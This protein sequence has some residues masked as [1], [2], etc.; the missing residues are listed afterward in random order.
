MNG[1]AGGENPIVLQRPALQGMRRFSHRAMNT[2]F[3][4][5]TIHGDAEYAAQASEEAFREIDRLELELSRFI[6]NSDVSR[7]NALKTGQSIR[8]GL[9]TFACLQ[10]SL[11]MHTL[12]GGAFD[13]AAGA[14]RAERRKRRPSTTE[15]HELR[16]QAGRCP[17]G[18][19]FELNE[20]DTTITALAD[21]LSI[22][23]GAIGK[24]YA[25]DV[26]AGLLR[27]WNIDSALLHGGMSTVLALEAPPGEGGWP[28]VLRPPGRSSNAVRGIHLRN[29]AVS[30]SGTRKGAHIVDPRTG[31][32]VTER[33]AAW[34]VSDEGARSD[35]LSTAFM[36]MRLEEISTYCADNPGTEA[37]VI[38][39]EWDKSEAGRNIVT[40]GG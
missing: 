31:K 13:V 6:E 36:V 15:T 14:L 18:A 25:L 23:L 37:I 12:T 9:D 2:L 30:A 29:R 34:A 21:G 33:E 28:L 35:A 26:V 20:A 11:R 39:K 4:I 3:E 7:I 17:A 22:D 40:F 27:D 1:R 24:G 38:L 8:L 32:P 19:I 5:F 16:P 10:D